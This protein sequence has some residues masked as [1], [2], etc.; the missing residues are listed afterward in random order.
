MVKREEQFS[1]AKYH[2]FTLPVA[3]TS[4]V[5]ARK[6]ARELQARNKKHTYYVEYLGRVAD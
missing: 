2:S 4:V 6:R 1:Y 5:T 3:Y